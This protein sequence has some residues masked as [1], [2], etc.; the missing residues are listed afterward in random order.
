MKV[1]VSGACG[2]IGRKLIDAL[3]KEFHSVVAI[4]DGK[5]YTQM[6][7]N[8]ELCFSEFHDWQYCLDNA[9]YSCLDGVQFA[10]LLGANSSTRATFHELMKPNLNS[11][12]G[13]INECKSRKIPVVFAS[14][15]AVYGSRFV[16]D[17]PTI[18]PLTMYGLTKL[19]MENWV[20]ALKYDNVVF[21]RYHNVYGE[22]EKH[23]GNMASIVSKWIHNYT[24]GILVNDLFYGSNNIRRD[25]I[26]VD[27]IVKV[28]IMFLDFY[29]VYQTL[30]SVNGDMKFDVGSGIATSFE[31]VAKQILKH[32]KGSVQYIINPYDD[33]NY[34]FYTRANTKM[35]SGLYEW[36]YSKKFEPMTIAE[37]VNKTF[38]DIILKNK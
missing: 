11:P 37:G 7:A 17:E 3:L 27:D 30:P 12:L 33:T 38:D 36:V 1:L 24:E 16:D 4:D 10:F 14:S 8:D 23:K 25:F 22:G 32:T 19:M 28:N 18:N 26:H 34:Q 5:I 29:I 6:L 35:I 31:D 2:F 13:I 20:N 15:G 21:L 9:D